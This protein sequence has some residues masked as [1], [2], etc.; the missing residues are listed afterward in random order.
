MRTT[1]VGVVLVAAWLTQGR[2]QAAEKA[3]AE[4]K[5]AITQYLAAY[6]TKDVDKVL[7]M[8]SSSKDVFAL[9]TDVAEVIEG[10]E[11]MRKQMAGDFQLFKSVSYGEPRNLHLLVSPD[12]KLATAI[13]DIEQNTATEGN[14]FPPKVTLRCVHVWKK[15]AGA[16]RLVQGVTSLPTT[17]E[18][19]PELI[20]KSKAKPTTK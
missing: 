5:Q 17:H 15:E 1:L 8:V 13:F 20:E 10:K 7:A 3:Q 12:G 11:A 6:Q 9:G 14:V 19:T 18:S 4:V 2:A 16:W